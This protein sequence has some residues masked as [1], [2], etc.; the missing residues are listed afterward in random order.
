M[1]LGISKNLGTTQLKILPG[2][3]ANFWHPKITM[4]NKHKNWDKKRPKFSRCDYALRANKIT[5]FT[6]LK[7]EIIR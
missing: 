6:F 7:I 2:P 4:G 3:L 5:G 1:K